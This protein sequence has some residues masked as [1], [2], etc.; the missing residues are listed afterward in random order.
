MNE[1]SD[2]KREEI[3]DTLVGSLGWRDFLVN[4]VVPAVVKIR[5]CLLTN[6]TLTEAQRIAYVIQMRDLKALF[7]APYLAANAKVPRDL[8]DLFS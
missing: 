7:A 6:E 5:R 8:E 1:P 2:F 3:Y 4:V